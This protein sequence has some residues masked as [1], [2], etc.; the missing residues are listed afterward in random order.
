MSAKYVFWQDDDMYLG[1][2]EEFP[3]CRTQGASREELEENLRDIRQDL[4]SG[5][6]PHV[7]EPT[8]ATTSRDKK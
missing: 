3:D 5:A 6:I 7:R 8:R 1:Y 2:W 4:L